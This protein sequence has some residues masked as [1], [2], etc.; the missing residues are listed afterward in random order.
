[1][2][3]WLLRNELRKAGQLLLGTK[4]ADKLPSKN[5]GKELDTAAVSVAGEAVVVEVVVVG[6]SVMVET[7]IWKVV[8]TEPDATAP[9]VP[10]PV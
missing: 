8:V 2:K 1:M 5:L 6:F 10:V 9:A 3:V 4:L 7:A